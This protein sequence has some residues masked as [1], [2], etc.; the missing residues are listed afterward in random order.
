MSAK[1]KQKKTPKS[2]DDCLESDDLDS[3][4]RRHFD[5]FAKRLAAPPANAYP[6][7]MCRN[8]TR[9]QQIEGWRAFIELLSGFKPRGVGIVAAALVARLQRYVY[10]GSARRA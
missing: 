9:D 7:R 4:A 1:K 2:V 6:R 5:G 3:A 8:I 10:N